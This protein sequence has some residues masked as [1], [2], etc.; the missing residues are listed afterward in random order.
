[1]NSDD[2]LLYITDGQIITDNNQILAYGRSVYDSHRS[3]RELME[4]N[5]LWIE[6]IFGAAPEIMRGRTD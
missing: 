2:L 3:S 5:R 1:M 4:E 6:S